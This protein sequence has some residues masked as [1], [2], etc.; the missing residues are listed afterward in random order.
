MGPTETAAAFA[1]RPAFVPYGMSPDRRDVPRPDFITSTAAAAFGIAASVVGRNQTYREAKAL[2]D[3]RRALDDKWADAISIATPDH[4]YA[5]MALLAMKAMS[6][7]S[8][9]YE[10]GWAPS[11]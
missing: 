6:P 10:P 1:P 3:F 5:P 2:G 8:R 7:W 11:A 9:S 4:G